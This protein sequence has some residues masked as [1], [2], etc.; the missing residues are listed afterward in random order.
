MSSAKKRFLVLND[1]DFDQKSKQQKNAN[2]EKSERK[3][4][5]VFR[6]FLQ[7]CGHCTMNNAIIGHLLKNLWI[8]T[9]QNS[10]LVQ[11]RLFKMIIVM[12][13]TMMKKTLI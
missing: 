5:K 1:E 3:A 8:I 4:D 12:M 13:R 10:G 2:T 7:A 9:S 6:N 11:E